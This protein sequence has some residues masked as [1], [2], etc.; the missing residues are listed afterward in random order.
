[1]DK[2]FGGQEGEGTQ[3]C[4]NSVPQASSLAMRAILFGAGL[5][6]TAKAVAN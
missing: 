4:D 5:S 6:S 1:M 3:N 2:N